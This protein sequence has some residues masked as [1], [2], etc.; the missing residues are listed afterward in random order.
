MKT[1]AITLVPQQ[2]RLTEKYISDRF[3][4]KITHFVTGKEVLKNLCKISVIEYDGSAYNPE[5]GKNDQELVRITLM[6]I[7]IPSIS[8]NGMTFTIFKG[9]QMFS[10]WK[11]RAEAY[12]KLFE[13]QNE[14]DSFDAFAAALED[15][16]VQGQV[17]FRA[18]NLSIDTIGYVAL[19]TQAKVMRDGTKRAKGSPELLPDGKTEHVRKTMTILCVEGFN[20][21]VSQII[22][23]VSSRLTNRDKYKIVIETSDDSTKPPTVDE[24]DA[25]IEVQDAT[26]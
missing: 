20:S 5:T 10:V 26:E 18:F 9:D 22:S 6:P 4:E 13:R 2:E 17:P 15:P 16:K 11:A 21:E 23:D 19:A 25:P 14:D 7:N 24:P 1:T 8:G 12:T 3:D